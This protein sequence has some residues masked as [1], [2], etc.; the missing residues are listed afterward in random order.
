MPQIF[1]RSSNAIAR[2]SLFGGVF[3]VIF[4]AW[5]AT[6]FVRSSYSTRGLGID[7]RYCHTSVEET[8]FAG[9][10]PTATCMNCHKEMWKDAELLAPVRESWST[11]KPIEWVRVHDL[12]DYVYFN[13]SVHLAK[14][15]GCESCHG[16]VDRMPLIH[17][18]ESLHMEWCLECHKAPERFLRPR[19]EVLTMGYRPPPPQAEPGA[20][21]AEEYYCSTCHR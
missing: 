11:G 1:H 18:A 20:E 19:S 4:L 3:I 6:I 16:R 13:H 2:I 8:A 15:V 10:P 12:P 21:L 5:F 9:V 14:G 7:C 17:K